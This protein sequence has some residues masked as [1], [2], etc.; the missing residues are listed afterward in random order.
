MTDFSILELSLERMRDAQIDLSNVPDLI[1]VER[2]WKKRK[3]VLAFLRRKLP[4]AEP[5]IECVVDNVHLGDG[6]VLGRGERARVAREVA[7][8]IVGWGQAVHVG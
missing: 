8:L 5:E 3:A 7:E 1:A 2:V 6:R 4:P